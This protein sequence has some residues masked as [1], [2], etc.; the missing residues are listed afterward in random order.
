MVK[1]KYLLLVFSSALVLFIGLSVAPVLAHNG[2]PVYP[3]PVVV[4]QIVPPVYHSP[5]NV[6]GYNASSVCTTHS[7]RQCR[8]FVNHYQPNWFSACLYANP[9]LH[10]C[11]NTPN[12][13]S[14]NITFQQQCALRGSSC[15]C[16]FSGVN[17]YTY[18]EAGFVY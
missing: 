13:F 7:G 3:Q 15:V 6:C 16:A 8:L 1:F 18:Y 2:Y 5:Y 17:G 11:V 10:A 12:H 14:G 9:F 4:P